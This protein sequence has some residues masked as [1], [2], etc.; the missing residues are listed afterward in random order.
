MSR[1]WVWQR[2]QTPPVCFS[3]LASQTSIQLLLK[4]Q[5]EWWFRLDTIWMAVTLP[6]GFLQPQ[7]FLLYKRRGRVYVQSTEEEQSGS[8]WQL[9]DDTFWGHILNE[10]LFGGSRRNK[11]VECTFSSSLCQVHAL[12][13]SVALARLKNSSKQLRAAEKH[14]P[15]GA[16][17]PQ[18][19]PCLDV[20]FIK[21]KNTCEGY[22]SKYIWNT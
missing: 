11:S 7:N 1:E 9:Q 20:M 14:S 13:I 19:H 4:F 22:I 21:Q 18:P 6:P 8:F 5:I 16:I 15:S 17:V 3:K 2:S 10:I 12:R